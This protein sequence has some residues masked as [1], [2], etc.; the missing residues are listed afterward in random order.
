MQLRGPLSSIPS[1][2]WL[3]SV[4]PVEDQ[5]LPVDGIERQWGRGPR[6]RDPR[7]LARRCRLTCERA[8]I[9]GLPLSA[10]GASSPAGC[11][12]PRRPVVPGVRH[13]YD[14][15]PL[16]SEHADSPRASP[17][18]AGKIRRIR[19]RFAQT[20]PNGPLRRP[21][22]DSRNG[23]KLLI[24]KL[25][26]KGG[27]EPPRSCERQPLKQTQTG[28]TRDQTSIHRPG[29]TQAWSDQ[30]AAD[31]SICTVLHMAL[32]RAASRSED[33]LPTPAQS[34]SRALC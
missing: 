7:G 31:D 17:L 1:A 6:R 16:R 18:A 24:L 23:C 14:H 34:R 19:T 8:G 25:V 13:D 20:G 33:A 4:T 9:E 26:R 30:P 15:P 5:T 27:F 22:L 3:V 29:R 10:C 28:V 32:G 11:R 21:I 2:S 12:P